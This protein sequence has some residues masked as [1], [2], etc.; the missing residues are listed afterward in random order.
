MWTVPAAPPGF[1]WRLVGGAAG[2]GLANLVLEGS[3]LQVAAVVRIR[4]GWAVRLG[5]DEAQRLEDYLAAPSRARAL[6]WAGRWAAARRDRWK[7]MSIGEPARAFELAP[8]PARRVR[9]QKGIEH[10]LYG[11]RGWQHTAGPGRAGK[12]PPRAVCY[13]TAR[14]LQAT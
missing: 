6:A 8:P 11:L 1:Q 5:P 3:W 4:D 10:A 13:L 9:E 7:A 2:Q 12:Q 14:G